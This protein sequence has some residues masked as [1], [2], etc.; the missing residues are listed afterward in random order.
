MMEVTGEIL[1]V[2]G[3]KIL[4]VP[5]GPIPGRTPIIVPRNTPMKQKSIFTG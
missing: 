1:N 5:D 3:S 2:K 4:M